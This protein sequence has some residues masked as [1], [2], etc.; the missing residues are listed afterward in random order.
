[1]ITRRI[2]VTNDDGVGSPGLGVLAARLAA[3][4]HD[5]FVVAP[6]EE[7]SGSSAAVGDIMNGV[8]IVTRSVE[9]PDAPGIPAVAV[10]GPPGR[11]VLLA[12]AGGFGPP[13]DLVLSG[14]N[15]GANVGQFLQL[16][17]GTLGAVLTAA[18][19]GLSGMAVSTTRPSPTN[20]G[21]AAE[22]AAR[23]VDYL[24]VCE[25]GTSLNLNVPDRPLDQIKGL[26]AATSAAGWTR[27]LDLV[28]V[29]PG[30]STMQWNDLP[31]S[32]P[33]DDSDLDLL[34]QRHAVLARVLPAMTV[35]P[36]PFPIDIFEN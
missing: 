2:L 9:L 25:P 24:A 16:H 32:E 35:A 22:L 6:S 3:D 4:G 21:S 28:G 14:I 7:S 31:G 23:L 13:P 19:F 36:E 17:S 8:A 20:W 11:C 10:D 26:R 34:K 27:R 33:A 1:L 18:G 30:D 5:V 15:P 12:V 29:S